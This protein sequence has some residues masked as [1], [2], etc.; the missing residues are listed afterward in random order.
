VLAELGAPRWL[1][2]VPASWTG[3]SLW[4]ALPD[5]PELVAKSADRDLDRALADAKR[6]LVEPTSHWPVRSGAD[7][8][9]R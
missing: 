3:V 2:P 4:V 1:T 5:H 7:Y 6:R 9:L 8:G